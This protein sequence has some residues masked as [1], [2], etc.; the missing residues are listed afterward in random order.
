M[1][2]LHYK[3]FCFIKWSTIINVE[4]LCLLQN[5]LTI[6]FHKKITFWKNNFKL[7]LCW[8]FL[9]ACFEIYSFPLSWNSWVASNLI[10]NSDWYLSTVKGLIRSFKSQQPSRQ[11]LWNKEGERHKK[12]LCFLKINASW[13]F[14][15]IRQPLFLIQTFEI[16]TFFLIF[17]LQ[18]CTICHYWG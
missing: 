8:K 7:S 9:E 16:S 18:T 15:I 12:V 5:P 11:N 3:K 2:T 6:A 1:W 14:C 13:F 10:L 17:T 4:L